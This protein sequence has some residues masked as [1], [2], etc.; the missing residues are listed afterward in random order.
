MSIGFVMLC[1]TALERAAEV[2]RHWAERDCP[3][4]IHVDKRVAKPAFDG[5]VAALADLGNIRFSIAIPFGIAAMIGAFAVE[6]EV[7]P[8][9]ITAAIAEKTDLFLISMGAGAAGHAQYLFSSRC[10]PSWSRRL[11]GARRQSLPA[12]AADD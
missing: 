7:V 3:V 12:D 9:A 1:H 2:A 8:H 4:V 10:N 11:S 5:L 6:I